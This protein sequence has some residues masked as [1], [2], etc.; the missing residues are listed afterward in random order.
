MWIFEKRLIAVSLFGLSALSLMC[1][2]AHADGITDLKAALAKLQGNAS[3]KAVLEAKSW[4]RQGEGKDAEE[5]QSVVSVSV[6]DSAR[7]MQ[8]L[9]SKDLLSRLQ[10]EEQAKQKDPKA[11]MALSKALKEFNSTELRPLLSAAAGLSS[12]LETAIFKSEK[13][14]TFNNKPAR[15]LSFDIP[16]EH[17]SEKDRKYIKKYESKLDIWIDSDGTPLASRSSEVASGRAFV[18]VSF[19]VKE[20]ENLVY[21]LV[22]DRLV[23]LKK[24]WKNLSS[25]AGER[26]EIR[27]IKTLQVQT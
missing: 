11:K 15:L 9:Y 21:G 16:V 20:D 6:E 19:D 27:V 23:V 7:G 1:G 17:L 14:D 8:V 12:R 22:G 10:A 4:N 18:V 13:N 24:E 25:G 5:M 2:N 26:N 3:L